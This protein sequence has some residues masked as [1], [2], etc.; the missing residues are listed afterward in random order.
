M[1]ATM[2]E[3]VAAITTEE[4]AT[5]AEATTRSHRLLTHRHKA[6]QVTPRIHMHSVSSTSGAFSTALAN[7]PMQTV[8][9]RTTWPYGISP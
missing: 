8:V 1:I 4:T 3:V 7:E 5:A 6:L 9:I 2:A